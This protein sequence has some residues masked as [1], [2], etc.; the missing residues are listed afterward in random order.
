MK[1]CLAVNLLV[2][3]GRRKKLSHHHLPVNN[4]VSQGI[5]DK[6]N[7]VHLSKKTCPTVKIFLINKKSLDLSYLLFKRTVL[8]ELFHYLPL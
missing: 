3:Y 4:L 5:L 8:I 2:K 7:I 1:Y 6:Q